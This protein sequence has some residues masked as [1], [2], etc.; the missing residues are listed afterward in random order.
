MLGKAEHPLTLMLHTRDCC[1]FLAP[2]LG[3]L[4]L[5]MK[6]EAQVHSPAHAHPPEIQQDTWMA[7]WCSSPHSPYSQNSPPAAGGCALLPLHKAAL[8]NPD[9][10][11]PSSSPEHR[12][13]LGYLQFFRMTKTSPHSSSEGRKISG[14]TMRILRLGGGLMF[15][16]HS[17]LAG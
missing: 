14:T 11:L 6:A 2:D 17:M 10:F 1:S 7:A 9:L 13:P 15:Q 4:T 16:V 8:P 12:G 5:K 3:L